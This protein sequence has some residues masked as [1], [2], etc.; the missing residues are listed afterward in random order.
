MCVCVAGMKQCRM[1][2]LLTCKEH[3]TTTTENVVGIVKVL[4]TA[5]RG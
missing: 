4:K 3:N 2:S 5:I 1:A